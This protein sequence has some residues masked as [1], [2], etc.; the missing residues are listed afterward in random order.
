VLLRG[1]WWVDRRRG[2]NRRGGSR[3]RRGRRHRRSVLLRGWWGNHRRR[4]NRRGWS[5]RRRRGQL[6]GL[7]HEGERL[8]FVV[9]VVVAVRLLV[10]AFDERGMEELTR[11]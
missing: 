2:K 6:E 5:R 3:R 4:R 8:P 1:R 9:V 7:R 11:P 10:D